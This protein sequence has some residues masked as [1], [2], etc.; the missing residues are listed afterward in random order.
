MGLKLNYK[1][2]YKQ[3]KQ[4][5]FAEIYKIETFIGLHR[6]DMISEIQEYIK[7]RIYIKLYNSLEDKE[8]G[9]DSFME[10]V[11]EFDESVKSINDAYKLLKKNSDFLD[12]I[13]I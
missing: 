11:R 4:E 6:I 10:T 12:A 8:N 5:V 3:D 7:T 9:C 1:T 13:E 2:P